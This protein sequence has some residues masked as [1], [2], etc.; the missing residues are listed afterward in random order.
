MWIKYKTAKLCAI[1]V[2]AV[3]LSPA[4]ASDS[5]GGGSSSDHPYVNLSPSFVTNYDGGGRLRYL[6]VDVAVR[7][8]R[9]TD[10]VVVNHLPYIRNALVELFSS[11][12]EEDLS[13]TQGTEK[14]RE[15]AL[16]AVRDAIDYLEGEGSE[17]IT[18]LY[19]TSFVIQQ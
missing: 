17:N 12:L 18:D 9:P 2:A 13:S 7:V 8:L 19:F 6:K 11:Q 3:F 5:G 15:E 14:L 4:H 10:M 16:A 1:I